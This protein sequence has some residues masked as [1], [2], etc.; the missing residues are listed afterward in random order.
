V[1]GAQ[2]SREELRALYGPDY[3]QSYHQEE[4]SR[5]ARLLPLLDLGPDVRVADF[6]CGNGLLLELLHEHI[7][8]YH[9]VDFSEEF[10]A[11][12]RRRAQAAGYAN[13]SFHH[14]S[15]GE[16]CSE[17]RGEIDR[18][19]AL[20]LVEH[21][22]D[23]ELL[24]IAAAMHGCLRADGRLYVHTPNRRYLLEILKERGILLRQLP[25][26]VAVRTADA[27]EALLRKA[28]FR[29]VRVAP[30]AHYVP[31]LARLHPL[32]RLPLL[33]PYFEARLFLEC[34]P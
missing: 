15:I 12:A 30:L 7:G 22:Y 5:L 25:E 17:R 10:I 14:Q 26:H 2:K 18:A 4:R 24:E 31:A 6:G 21:V 11:E 3:V 1:S 34:R 29:E 16:F 8:V 32:S 13:A 33:G 28:G 19:F 27:T 9:G 20:D 23:D